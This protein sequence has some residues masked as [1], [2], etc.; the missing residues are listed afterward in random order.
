MEA[1][2]YLGRNDESRRPRSRDTFYA[3]VVTTWASL[4]REIS[5]RSGMIYGGRDDPTIA[6]ITSQLTNSVDE[7]KSWIRINEEL[8]TFL[9]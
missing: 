3:F 1:L 6:A 9:A 2:A 4:R 7:P 8:S 5:V